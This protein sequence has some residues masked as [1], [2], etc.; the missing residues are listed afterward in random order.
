MSGSR[1]RISED[2]AESEYQNGFDEEI[3][4][5]DDQKHEEH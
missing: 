5:G 1:L 3:Y 4:V 2:C